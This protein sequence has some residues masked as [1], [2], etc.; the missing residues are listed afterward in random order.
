[1]RLSLLFLLAVVLAVA[2][3]A[4]L[5]EAS[6]TYGVTSLS[7]SD[8]TV[9]DD[10]QSEIGDNR[11][12]MAITPTRLFH[13]GDNVMVSFNATTLADDV[14]LPITDGI[15]SDL[16]DG[17]LWALAFDNSTFLNG[18]D[19]EDGTY[20]ITHVIPLTADNATVNA[21][22]SVIALSQPLTRGGGQGGGEARCAGAHVGRW[23]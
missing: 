3:L 1:M 15:I 20:N 11:S 22:R 10:L 9:R 7:V 2:A 6:R 23:W 19:A 5:S 12:S 21:S 13:L 14:L 16:G 8:C 17:A 4:T 18:N